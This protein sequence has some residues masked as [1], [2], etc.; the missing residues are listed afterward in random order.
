M[1][2]CLSYTAL[3][4]TRK[5]WNTARN[6]TRPK[7]DKFFSSIGY[8]RRKFLLLTV[9]L[10]VAGVIQFLSIITDLEINN[11]KVSSVFQ[12]LNSNLK[13]KTEEINIRILDATTIPNLAILKAG[14]QVLNCSISIGNWGNWGRT[15]LGVWLYKVMLLERGR[16]SS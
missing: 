7:G 4:V 13:L 15:T 3:L 10:S 6:K 12:A 16:F 11:E 8:L 1:A 14:A 5:Q 2:L 9:K